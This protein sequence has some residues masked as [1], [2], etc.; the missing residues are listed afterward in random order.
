MLNF[1][2]LRQELNVSREKTPGK[3]AAA[4]SLKNYYDKKAGIDTSVKAKQPA[5]ILKIKQ[6]LKDGYKRPKIRD[7]IVKEFDVTP[8]YFSIVW[9]KSL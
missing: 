1:E 2:S 7:V 9:N 6:M 3:R 5:M 4:T 8:S